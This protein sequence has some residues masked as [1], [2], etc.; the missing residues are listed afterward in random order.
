MPE[1]TTTQDGAPVDGTPHFSVPEAIYAIAGRCFNCLEY[2]EE[3][4]VP[5][6]DGQVHCPDCGAMMVTVS[7]R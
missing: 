5:S 7:S 3:I 1:L 4:L 6:V 2:H